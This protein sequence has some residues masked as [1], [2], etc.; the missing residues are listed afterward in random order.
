MRQAD[1]QMEEEWHELFNQ[2][3][4]RC[5]E[6][7]CQG[8]L[9][10]WREV[11][12]HNA[13]ALSSLHELHYRCSEECQSRDDV[14]EEIEHFL[15]PSEADQRRR[16][17]LQQ[18]INVAQN[19]CKE[20]ICK[21]LRENA[22]KGVK[23]Q[24]VTKLTVLYDQCMEEC[25][26]NAEDL[27]DLL[28][29]LDMKLSYWS[30]FKS[31]KEA[32]TLEEARIFMAEIESELQLLIEKEQYSYDKLE[33]LEKKSVHWSNFSQVRKRMSVEDALTYWTKVKDHFK[34]TEKP[35]AGDQN[36]YEELTNRI[37][38]TQSKC[39]KLIKTMVEENNRT[40][41]VFEQLRN[42]YLQ[43]MNETDM[44]VQNLDDL[45]EEIMS[46]HEDWLDFI[47]DEIES[48]EARL[49][50]EDN[51]LDYELLLKATL[52]LTK[53]EKELKQKLDARIREQYTNCKTGQC[54]HL[55]KAV[56]EAKVLKYQDIAVVRFANCMKECQTPVE[57]DKG[58]LHELHMKNEACKGMKKMREQESIMAALSHYEQ[59]Q[60]GGKGKDSTLA[61]EPIAQGFGGWDREVAMRANGSDPLGHEPPGLEVCLKVI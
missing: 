47:V 49:S 7:I 50:W 11:V 12:N 18:R 20:G 28:H 26:L 48:L 25:A 59:L 31:A 42:A 30:L 2:R 38:Q 53:E 52:T 17:E 32:M 8:L 19:V 34:V 23:Y 29:E 61:A 60:L 6:R 45:R 58:K 39:K 21:D 4:K 41:E 55:L 16:K 51:V 10:N 57:G 13:S 44:K 36:L 56:F 33:E 46:K 27:V 35:S 40:I 15:K 1:R 54:A 3:Q 22:E 43:C 14:L 5:D 9:D 37:N 24:K